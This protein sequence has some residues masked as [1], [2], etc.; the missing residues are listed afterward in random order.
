M[1]IFFY[2]DFREV[3]VFYGLIANYGV[4]ILGDVKRE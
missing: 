2:K 1:V 3:N 4:F